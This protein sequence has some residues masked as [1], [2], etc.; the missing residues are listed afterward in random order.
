V[1]EAREE[2]ATRDE[3]QGGVELEDQ[4]LTGLE[5]FE[6]G[7]WRR[8]PEIRL[9]DAGTRG[10]QFKPVLV[11]DGNEYPHGNRFTQVYSLGIA[12]GETRQGALACFSLLS[13]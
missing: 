9:V 2:S 13:E 12:C 3:V 4:Q 5:H 7:V 10:M 1:K 8:A 11:S 6:V